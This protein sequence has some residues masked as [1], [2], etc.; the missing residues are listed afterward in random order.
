METLSK[1][2]LVETLSYMDIGG[3]LAFKST[4]TEMNQLNLASVLAQQEDQTE[5]LYE[6][7]RRRQTQVVEASVRHHSIDEDE[8]GYVLNR[9]WS[10]PAAI[11]A[12]LLKAGTHQ[13]H[14]NWAFREQ[15]GLMQSDLDVLRLLLDAGVEQEYR[16]EVL[17][18][19]GLSTEV[20]MVLEAGVT[21]DALR[22]LWRSWHARICDIRLN[23]EQHDCDV[24]DYPPPDIVRRVLDAGVS[25]EERNYAMSR[26]S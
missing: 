26:E 12:L 5:V 11:V 8:R 1:D 20:E 2:L 9:W 15:C 4:S 18:E 24:E 19:L 7:V 23:S 21:D 10:T 3:I 17:L 13:N 22:K 25:Q 16:D 6:A 14:R